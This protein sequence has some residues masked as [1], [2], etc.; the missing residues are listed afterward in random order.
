MAEYIEKQAFVDCYR[1]SYCGN[2]G[3]RRGMKNGKM[4]VLYE[5]GDAPC[6]AC[7][8]DDMITAVEDFTSADV[9]PV[10][11]G[12]WDAVMLDHTQM[13]CRPTAHYC[14]ECHQITWFRTFYCPN[15]GAKM[16]ASE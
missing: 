11:H 6:R 1:K 3:K 14:S 12:R 4:K 8:I 15:C 13:G 10:R 16:E 5:I 7:D 2:C 9:Q